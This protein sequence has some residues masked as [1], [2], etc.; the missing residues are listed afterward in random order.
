[1]QLGGSAYNGTL[2]PV[3]DG[4]WVLSAA[5]AASEEDGEGFELNDVEKNWIPFVHN[6]TLY[7]S[8]SLQVLQAQQQNAAPSFITPPLTP[9]PPLPCPHYY[10]SHTSY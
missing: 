8:Y 5:A 6:N 4:M 7:L 9:S 2:A 3:Q 1:M 10:H